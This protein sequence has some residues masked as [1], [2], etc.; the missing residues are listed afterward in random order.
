MIHY[1]IHQIDGVAMGSPLGSLLA[2]IF[3][4]ELEIVNIISLENF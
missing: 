2:N 1:C 3:M 4:A